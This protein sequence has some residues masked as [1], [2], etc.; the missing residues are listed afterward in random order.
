MRY[1]T[2]WPQRHIRFFGR[3]WKDPTILDV[4]IF[5]ALTLLRRSTATV[6]AEAERANGVAFAR[7]TGNAEPAWLVLR[8]LIFD[9][10]L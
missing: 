3:A 4:S 6:G 1:Q 7:A 9:A 5:A 8:E 2:S 10:I